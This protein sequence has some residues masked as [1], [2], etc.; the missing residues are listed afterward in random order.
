MKYQSNPKVETVNNIITL[1]FIARSNAWA[2]HFYPAASEKEL[3]GF[4]I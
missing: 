4:Q 2:A 1:Y 3:N